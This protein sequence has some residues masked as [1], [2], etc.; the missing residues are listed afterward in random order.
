MQKLCR[1]AIGVFLIG[2]FVD[3]DQL[4]AATY[5]FIPSTVINSSSSAPSQRYTENTFP[6]ISLSVQ[7]SA[8]QLGFF[9]ANYTNQSGNYSGNYFLLSSFS[10]G[11]IVNIS[12]NAG[13]VG[14]FRANLLFDTDGNVSTGAIS[15]NSNQ[16]GIDLA[17]SAGAL[18]GAFNSANNTN[19]GFVSGTFVTVPEPTSLFLL[20]GSMVCAVWLRRRSSSQSI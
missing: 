2:S 16:F 19:A 1:L 8:V 17:G 4:K 5:T 9:S 13:D 10:I 3:S 6:S 14:V 7:D 12:S 18:Q 15:F 11:N 20:S